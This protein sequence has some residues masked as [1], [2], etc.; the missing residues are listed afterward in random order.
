ML[1]LL[2]LVFMLMATTPNCNSLPR[3]Q[4]AVVRPPPRRGRIKAQIFGS[5]AG[6]ISSFAVDVFANIRGGRDSSASTSPPHSA[7]GDQP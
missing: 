2:S 5:L 4:N 7:Y 3:N 1:T 6:T